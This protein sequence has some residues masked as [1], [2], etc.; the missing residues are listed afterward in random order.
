[1]KSLKEE[2][3]DDVRVLFSKIFNRRDNPVYQK[4]VQKVGESWKRL[5]FEYLALYEAP[6]KYTQK[7]REGKLRKN[8]PKNRLGPSHYKGEHLVRFLEY[9]IRDHEDTEFKRTDR[10]ILVFLTSRLRDGLRE[11]F[12]LFGPSSRDGRGASDNLGL[13]WLLLHGGTKYPALPRRMR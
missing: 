7:S 12:D 13:C 3:S 8:Q 1:M 9:V 11:T 4:L 2:F 5:W 10:L 6:V